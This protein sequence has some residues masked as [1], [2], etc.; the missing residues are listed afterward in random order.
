[1][2]LKRKI[3]AVIL[4][5]MLLICPVQKAEAIA[6]AIA[7]AIYW[8][9]GSLIVS[10]G[11]YA[12][13]NEDLQY[14]IADYWDNASGNIKN[15]WRNTAI[16]AGTAGYLI[17]NHLMISDMNKYL[18]TSFETNQVIQECIMPDITYPPDIVTWMYEKTPIFS[19]SDGSVMLMG[20]TEIEYSSYYEEYYYVIGYDFL[21]LS[22]RLAYGTN[23]Y[24]NRYINAL[25]V[26]VKYGTIPEIWFIDKTINNLTF[27][28]SY[29]GL[30]GDIITGTR[31]INVK[32]ADIYDLYGYIVNGEWIVDAAGIGTAL[33]PKDE[34]KV[35]CPPVP[36]VEWDPGWINDLEKEL[37]KTGNP[38]LDAE[39][40]IDE[41]EYEWD[42]YVDEHGNI[43]RVKKGEPPK[44][45]Q[46]DRQIGFPVP[47]PEPNVPDH[48]PDINNPDETVIDYPPETTSTENPDGTRTDTTTETTTT[49]R[50]WYD[51]TTERWKET[52]TTTT[53]T[54]QQDYDPDGLPLGPPVTTTTTAPPTTTT[55]TPPTDD[56][57]I[58]FEPLKKLPHFITTRFPFSLP[59][60]LKRGIESL[61][62]SEW[63][64]KFTIP[65]IGDYWPAMEIDISMF[66]NIAS[67]TRVILLI[68]FDFGLIF[69]TRRL[70]GGDV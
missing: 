63:D 41:G 3:T 37:N 9:I 12:S 17:I 21:F 20:P 22:S 62:G 34:L 28:Y 43:Y 4:I 50:R 47:L 60:D 6:P 11:V 24:W 29:Q 13:T 56:D 31:T 52:T 2:D 16:Y 5:I 57:T 14:L 40:K 51:P 7:P 25:L 32:F 66:D 8:G 48:F 23:H 42:W 27:G 44:D 35:P 15:M 55:T 65:A 67:M 19:F 61:E 70:M 26:S 33:A 54:T 1:M 18:N 58:N 39:T 53:T 38:D 46:K 64:R 36:E 68:V 10:S 30:N 49:T 59:W 69:A 45:P